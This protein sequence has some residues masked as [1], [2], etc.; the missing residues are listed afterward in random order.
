MNGAWPLEGRRMQAVAWS[1]A[2][3]VVKG[4]AEKNL[5]GNNLDGKLRN[6]NFNLKPEGNPMK[7]FK[8]SRGILGQNGSVDSGL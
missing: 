2:K 6:L 1:N 8:Y 7:E 3:E 4:Q 5:G